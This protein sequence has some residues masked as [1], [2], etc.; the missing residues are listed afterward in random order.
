MEK[1]KVGYDCVLCGDYGGVN[2]YGNSIVCN[3][4]ATK[5]RNSSVIF[6]ISCKTSRGKKTLM[7]ESCEP[8]WMKA[9]QKAYENAGFTV[10]KVMNI[11]FI[12][13]GCFHCNKSRSKCKTNVK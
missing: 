13:G 12:K 1:Q 10:K 9:Q 5:L 6:C 8:K 11:L 7:W 2:K 3:R 4:C